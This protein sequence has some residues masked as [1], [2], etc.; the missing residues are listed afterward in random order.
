LL[1]VISAFLLKHLHDRQK[2]WC[3]AWCCRNVRH[4]SL[5]TPS[6]LFIVSHFYGRMKETGMVKLGWGV[7]GCNLWW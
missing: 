6:S 7:F 3:H 5:F 4:L 2:F 1:H